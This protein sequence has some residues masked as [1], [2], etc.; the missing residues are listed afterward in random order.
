MPGFEGFTKALTDGLEELLEKG[1]FT[2]HELVKA[3]K[4]RGPHIPKEHSTIIQDFKSKDG[5]PHEWPDRTR[6]L[7]L[8]F[9]PV[10]GR[11][12]DKSDR[13]RTESE[14]GR[15]WI[16]SEPDSEPA[17]EHSV[18]LR[19]DFE[20]KLSAEQLRTFGRGLNDVFE[21]NCLGLQKIQWGGMRATESPRWAEEE[22]DPLI[23]H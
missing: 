23:D 22:E 16:E 14:D 13:S 6:S 19:F 8:R 3:I 4:A 15:R 9:Y 20:D 12:E 2:I 1:V 11:W 18:T 10:H 17:V 21:R 7:P 5:W